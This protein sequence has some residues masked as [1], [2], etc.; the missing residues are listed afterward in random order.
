MV[1]EESGSSL[2]PDERAIRAV[3]AEYDAAWQAGDIEGLLACLADDA[4]LVNP[5]NE[6]ARGHA[7]IKRELEGVLNGLARGSRHT[8][9]VS[10][11]EFLT[12]D[13]AIVDGEAVVDIPGQGETAPQLLTHRFTDV[14]VKKGNRWK[15]AHVRAYS[16]T[17]R[18]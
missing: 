11:L 8:S 5:R 6:M 4:V 16:L 10:R 2:N 13:V 9:L 17:I 18:G 1:A 7:E 12:P 15:I 3:E 14:L